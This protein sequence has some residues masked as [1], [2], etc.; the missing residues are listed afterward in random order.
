MQIQV[1]G[2]AMSVTAPCS[3]NDLLHKME[4]SEGRV[5]IEVNRNIIPRSEHSSHQLQDGDQIE[6][7]HAIGGG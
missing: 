1:N 2:E 4:M 6:I 7:V 5:A 3:L